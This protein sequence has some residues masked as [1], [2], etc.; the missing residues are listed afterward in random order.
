MALR[1]EGKNWKNCLSS[2]S[3]LSRE[4]EG[5]RVTPILRSANEKWEN[6]CTEK[7]WT[8]L[9]YPS[10]CRLEMHR[11]SNRKG[12]KNA[13]QSSKAAVTFLLVSGGLH[14]EYECKITE[15]DLGGDS[16]TA[17]T[18]WID[19]LNSPVH[20]FSFREYVFLTLCFSCSCYSVHLR[21]CHWLT[22]E[23]TFP[24]T[25]NYVITQTSLVD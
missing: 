11:G 18:R 15:S 23:S 17:G 8:H 6:W 4:V 21:V 22:V 3:C 10:G 12:C 7:W 14:P 9:H 24:W 2:T 5:C 25:I 16:I 19:C 1:G 20:C 13:R